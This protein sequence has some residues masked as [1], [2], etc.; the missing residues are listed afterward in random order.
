[1]N[2]NRL[3]CGSIGDG[4][5]RSV[6]A[7]SVCSSI[8][9]LQLLVKK[10]ESGATSINPFISLS[11]TFESQ[12]CQR[13]IDGYNS[14]IPPTAYEQIA[15]HIIICIYFHINKFNSPFFSVLRICP[16]CIRTIGR[17]GYVSKYFLTKSLESG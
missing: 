13:S 3:R 12:Q 10:R 1:M 4:S 16:G 8:G 6:T 2:L 7:W 14:S 17:S 5:G 9:G 11:C 15:K